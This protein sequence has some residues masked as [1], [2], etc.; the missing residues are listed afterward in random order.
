MLTHSLY[1]YFD[2][3][4]RLQR[5]VS[6]LSLNTFIPF[7]TLLPMI[8]GVVSVGRE[9]EVCAPPAMIIP[10]ASVHPSKPS[11]HHWRNSKGIF[12]LLYCPVSNIFI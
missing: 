8:S 2:K 7:I 4:A 9:L 11:V 1:S 5:N 3:V 10:S 6:K 12:F